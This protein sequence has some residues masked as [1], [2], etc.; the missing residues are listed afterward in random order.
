M[1]SSIAIDSSTHEDTTVT[2]AVELT[3]RDEEF[4]LL[5]YLSA[6]ARQES[7]SDFKLFSNKARNIGIEG[8][9]GF[10]ERII[11]GRR[12]ELLGYHHVQKSNETQHEIEAV[13]TALLIDDILNSY[14]DRVVIIDGGKQKAKPVINALHGVRDTIPSVTH[15]FRS[16][17]YYP[18]SL[19]ADLVASYISHSINIG[20]YDYSDPLLQAPHAQRR[21]DRWGEAFS[22]MKR[23]SE[24]YRM[25]DLAEL[26]GNSPSQRVH[27]WYRGGM[28]RKNSDSLRSDAITPIIRQADKNGFD[29]AKAELE[30]LR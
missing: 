27:C 8:N 11:E 23:N 26:R 28:A 9:E 7:V 5:D 29:S 25:L 10:F 12:E 15:C 14:E 24:E 4:E 6:A 2:I 17:T 21:E 20:K 30:R 13:H 16:E 3:D 18:Q 22:A 1:E 19:F